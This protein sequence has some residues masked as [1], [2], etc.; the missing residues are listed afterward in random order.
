MLLALGGVLIAA[1]ALRL[2]L[3]MRGQWMIDYDEAVTG[4]A[5]KHI[6]EGE[7]PIFMFS[8]PYM[9]PVESYLTAVVFAAAGIS[10]ATLKVIP[11]AL[12]LAFIGLTFCLAREILNARAALIAALLAAL[13]PVYATVHE[14]KAW[15]STIETL[16]FGTLLL[17]MAVHLIYREADARQQTRLYLIGGVVIGLAFW[18][19]FLVAY[20][21]I[22]IGLV[23]FWRDR[24]FFLRRPIWMAVPTFFLG[25]LPF[26][27]Y[28]IQHPLTSFRYLLGGSSK[29]VF[30]PH[31][32]YL[33][34]AQHLVARDLPHVLGVPWNWAG[35]MGV[36][37]FA[38]GMA[39]LAAVAF[40]V[41]AAWRVRQIA[42]RKGSDGWVGQPIDLPLIFVPV[43][44][45]VYVFSGFGKPAVNAYGID[46]SGRYLIPLLAILPILLAAALDALGRRRLLLACGALLVILGLNLYS[47]YAAQPLKMFQSP[48]FNRL[49]ASS[50]DLIQ[51]LRDNG[52]RHV[53]TDIGIALPL[54]FDSG[55]DILATDYFAP[56][57]ASNNYFPAVRRAVTDADTSAYVV[58]GLPGQPTR[59]ESKL[60]ELGV[61]YTVKELSPYV[62]LVPRSRKVLPTEVSGQLGFQ[63]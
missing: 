17:L 12:S 48:Y 46:A 44:L 34:V 21:L 22:T 3:A 32:G 10:R 37:W 18:V 60:R 20:Y 54:M 33:D 50:K 39:G 16:V 26:W 25:S 51:Y 7:R 36:E 29:P 11:F 58:I 57:V 63:Y 15:G 19:H 45:V 47:N 24:R 55:E 52:L 6:L 41:V 27:I 61:G 40:L 31:I 53:W 42:R 9:G 62:V 23:L 14:M 38:R 8:V 5:A 35:S 59:L 30:A 2:A 56:W 1:L 4:L 13:P 28:N 49:P 43:V